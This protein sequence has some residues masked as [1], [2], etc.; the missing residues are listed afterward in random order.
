[1]HNL[2]SEG[3]ICIGDWIYNCSV[4]LAFTDK[5]QYLTCQEGPWHVTAL[6]LR[7]HLCSQLQEGWGEQQEPGGREKLGG[8]WGR[9][10]SGMNKGR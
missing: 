4:A 5:P 3:T 8:H 2:Y 7:S 1:M 9:F 10:G 6:G